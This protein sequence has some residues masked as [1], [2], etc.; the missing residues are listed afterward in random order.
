[1][2]KW[3]GMLHA[4]HR[5]WTGAHLSALRG[6]KQRRMRLL[7]GFGALGVV[8]RALHQR[9]QVLCDTWQRVYPYLA[10]VPVPRLRHRFRPKRRHVPGKL[11]LVL[12]C[13]GAWHMLCQRLA[14][15]LAAAALAT[16]LATAAL[17]AALATA[18]AAA[19]LATTLAAAALAA[20]A[21]A[22]SV[23]G[24]RCVQGRA[25]LPRQLAAEVGKYGLS[26]ER[27]GLWLRLRRLLGVGRC[28]LCQHPVKWLLHHEH[29]RR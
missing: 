7:V 4:R 15:A 6:H 20:A 23:G 8:R 1:V 19:A 12:H 18:I 28:R 9:I 22:T 2:S 16:A 26:A 10:D 17:A 29:V 14:A 5:H 11:A 24:A 13:C 25:Q 21:L 27:V 3:E